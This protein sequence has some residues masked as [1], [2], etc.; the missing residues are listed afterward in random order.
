MIG[1]ARGVWIVSEGKNKYV[2]YY[3]I[4]GVIVNAILNY[5]LIPHIGIVGAA[6]ATLVTQIVTS[7]IA[8][9]F[10]K[11]TRIHSKYVIESFA[12]KWLFVKKGEKH[13]KC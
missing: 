7:I 4:Y 10:Y 12:L 11:E 3:L 6:V 9:L 13:G 2:K 8:P 1:T 5:A